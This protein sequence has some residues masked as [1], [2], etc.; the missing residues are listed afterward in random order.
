MNEKVP[1]EALPQIAARLE[2]KVNALTETVDKLFQGLTI[3]PA[4]QQE[5]MVTIQSASSILHLSVSRV[6]ALVQ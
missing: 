5:E 6:R 1:F 3:Q 4:P 2:E